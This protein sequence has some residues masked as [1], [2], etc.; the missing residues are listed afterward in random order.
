MIVLSKKYLDMI[1]LIQF[2]NIIIVLFP[3]GDIAIFHENSVFKKIILI[4]CRRP[5][6]LS[7]V[8]K[9]YVYIYFKIKK[10]S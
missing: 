8:K 6:W 2:C 5:K 3:M 10:S 1:F 4:C 9:K 7:K